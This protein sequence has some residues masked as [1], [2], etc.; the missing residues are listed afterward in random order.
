MLV[1]KLQTDLFMISKQSIQNQGLEYALI[2]GLLLQ[3]HQTEGEEFSITLPQLAVLSGLSERS[4]R[5]V[6]K[7]MENDG[8]I[9][10]S[11]KGIPAKPFIKVL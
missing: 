6:L 1:K 2:E 7:K 11:L 5:I 3:K 4:V 10:R 8:V 9:S